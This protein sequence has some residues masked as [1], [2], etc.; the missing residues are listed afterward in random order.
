MPTMRFVRRFLSFRTLWLSTILGL[1]VLLGISTVFGGRGLLHLE[2]LAQE[3]A[4]LEAGVFALLRENEALRDCI[5]RLE[6]DD[7]FL[8]KVV[9]GEFGFVRPG[10][11]VY[12][13]EAPASE[14]AAPWQRACLSRFPAD[15]PLSAG[16]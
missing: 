5:G 9:R 6:T 14:A 10:D 4:A 1:Y 15:V 13:F 7:A 16:D 2:G 12:R 3:R 8:E 11:L